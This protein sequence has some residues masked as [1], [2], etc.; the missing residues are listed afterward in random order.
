MDSIYSLG[1]NNVANGKSLNP[2][3]DET[4]VD[5]ETVTDTNADWRMFYPSMVINDDL[6]L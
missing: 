3:Q 1:K 6:R 5:M 2:K 4:E